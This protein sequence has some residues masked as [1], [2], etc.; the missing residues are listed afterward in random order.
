MLVWF[1][2][3]ANSPTVTN[4]S[5]YLMLYGFLLIDSMRWLLALRRHKRNTVISLLCGAELL[6]GVLPHLAVSVRHELGDYRRGLAVILHPPEAPEAVSMSG[7]DV[8]AG[9]RADILFK[10][11]EFLRQ[12]NNPKV[13]Y[14]TMDCYLIPKL[15][16]VWSSIPMVEVFEESFQNKRYQWMLSTIRE[17]G[18]AEIYFDTPESIQASEA[19]S[20]NAQRHNIALKFFADLR[21]ELSSH[22]EFARNESGWEVW[23]LRKREGAKEKK[24]VQ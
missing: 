23:R 11:A 12:L 9:D 19:D 5:S 10:K 8:P 2:Y 7:I 4:F 1:S 24:A 21:R 20:S 22:Y 16:G 17:S 6:L 18:Q 3:F 15:A 14:L 13:I